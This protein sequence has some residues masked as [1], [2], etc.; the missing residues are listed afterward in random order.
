MFTGRRFGGTPR[1]LRPPISTS[2]LSGSTNP[3][4]MRSS[5]VLPQP[6][7]P[8]MAKRLPRRTPKDSESTTTWLP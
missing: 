5:V 1:M 8:R 7:G 2:P 3:A 4:I 6:E